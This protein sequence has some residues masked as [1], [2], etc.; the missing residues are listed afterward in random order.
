M[1]S[2]VT[3]DANGATAPSTEDV[4]QS[5]LNDWQAAFDNQLNPDMATPQG[6]LVVS[7]AAIV[8][9][10]NA[11]L[12]FLANMFDPTFAEGRWQD[13]LASIYFLTRQAARPTVVY[14]ECT[15]LQG[16]VI[17][18]MDTSTDFAIVKD[19]AGN[20]FWCQNTTTIPASGTVTIPFQASE[21]G[22][23]EV[24]RNSVTTIVT[25]I[26]GWDTVT[27]S[28]PGVLGRNAE[29]QRDF[30]I[31][32]AASVALNSRSMIQSVFSRV[33]QVSGVIDLLVAQNRGDEE[34][35]E[36]GITLAPHSVYV[37]VLG[38]EDHDVAE[39]LYDTTSAGCDYNGNTHYEYKDEETGV[40]EDVRFDRPEPVDF[41]INIDIK[42]SKDTPSDI[43]DRIK[44]NVY[45]E[46]YGEEYPNPDASIHH[47]DNSRIKI[48]SD[49]Y[50]SRFYCPV[51]SAGVSDL[52]SVTFD[53]VVE[54]ATPSVLT[55]NDF[56]ID[57]ENE[58]IPDGTQGYLVS[59]EFR[60][61]AFTDFTQ[62]A[63]GS[64]CININGNKVPVLKLDYR[65]QSS[66]ATLVT[67]LANKITGATVTA[68]EDG[69]RLIITSNTFGVNSTVSDAYP[70]DLL[71]NNVRDVSSMLKLTEATGARQ[72]P[73]KPY[74]T[75]RLFF[76]QLNQNGSFKVTIGD[77]V[78][79]YR[80]VDMQ[81][82]S[83]WDLIA[84]KIQS[85]LGD[86]ATVRVG[87]T[88]RNL[89]V[90]SPDGVEMGYF[91]RRTGDPKDFTHGYI[92]SGAFT[93][94]ATI[95]KVTKGAFDI[96][97][98]GA[99]VAVKYLNFSG[100]ADMEGLVRV[101][102]NQIR[103][104]TVRI[105]E[106]SEED[107]S[108]QFE[109]V[110][111]TTGKTS[112]VGFATTPKVLDGCTD[113][114]ETLKLTSAT[115]AQTTQ[116]DDLLDS[117]SPA[118]LTTGIFTEYVFPSVTNGAFEIDIDETT[119]Q[120]TGIDLRDVTTLQLVMERLNARV[121]AIV[122]DAKAPA[123]SK[124]EGPDHLVMTSKIT[125]K[126]SVISFARPPA[127]KALTDVSALFHMT[128]ATGAEIVPGYDDETD[129][130]SGLQLSAETAVSLVESTPPV[131]TTVN[132][133][134]LRY[135]QYPSLVRENI[136]VN[137]Q[138]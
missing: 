30:E 35:E 37:S 122:T 33:G 25:V 84:E 40:I 124:I 62:T 28:E 4:I 125:G 70:P 99:E 67:L 95:A 68:N 102:N 3:F 42:T 1:P 106:V 115:Q 98:D 90:Q 100:V 76:T 52:L 31:R 132:E 46:F 29:T 39:A 57:S 93:E 45:A 58:S 15:G 49:T 47:P 135:N 89:V 6:Q 24:I 5:V 61:G 79:T 59:G 104:A 41:K 38:G 22:P 118:T 138:E 60:E 77:R 64:F 114:S 48:G 73:G 110:S 126:H 113:I 72:Y 74:D 94:Y 66:V 97:I 17:P 117:P 83:D 23:L 111:D 65:G 27:N 96:T 137:I 50:A 121:Q 18:G 10:K 75:E 133:I 108:N 53:G 134:K 80:H 55:G 9:D 81:G 109:I 34:K 7:E 13:A 112:T 123:I 36:G 136:R 32:R 71:E 43:E 105:K 2:N 44:D 20:E 92:T 101:L 16:V 129:L 19:V 82:F 119:Y 130:A 85:L 128:E 14:C 103:G 116:G 11:Q 63:S 12:L 69:T 127:D 88:G 91:E 21:S 107:T 86:A 120:I 56:R 78:F 54:P 8:Q 87:D 51:L 26:N 131:Q